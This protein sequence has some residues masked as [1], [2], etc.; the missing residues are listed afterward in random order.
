MQS[1]EASWTTM[2][3]INSNALSF[4]WYF[5]YPT[6]EHKHDE[7]NNISSRQGIPEQ[8]KLI[9]Q[10]YIELNYPTL[11][12][13]IVKNFDITKTSIP[14]ILDQSTFIISRCSCTS[15]FKNYICKHIVTIFSM[16]SIYPDSTITIPMTAKNPKIKFF[17]FFFIF[18][19]YL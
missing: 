1:S 19:F 2:R 10:Q 17:L 15:Y 9:I 5:C 11:D 14:L 7:I 8:T 3:I 4:N 6:F 18:I 13:F 16:K 12:H